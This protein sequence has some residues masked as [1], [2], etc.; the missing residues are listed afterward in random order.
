[1]LR[2]LTK[3]LILGESIRVEPV[4]SIQALFDI[5]SSVRVTNKRDKNRMSVA[6]EHLKSIKRHVRSLNERVNALE[7]Q[8]NLLNEEK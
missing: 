2:N 6:Q 5:V 3:K 1:V 7:E 8:L 4:A